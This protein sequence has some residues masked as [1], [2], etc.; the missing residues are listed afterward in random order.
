MEIHECVLSGIMVDVDYAHA[1]FISSSHRV[2][3]PLLWN[4]YLHSTLHIYKLVD[5]L[6]NILHLGRTGDL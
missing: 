2:S 5:S 3:S 1:F 4:V 6:R